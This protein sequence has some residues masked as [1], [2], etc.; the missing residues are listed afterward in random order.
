MPADNRHKTYVDPD[1]VF[2]DDLNAFQDI[3]VAMQQISHP[4]TSWAG[5]G[6]NEFRGVVASIANGAAARL[7]VHNAP[8]GTVFEW[9]QR[10]VHVR[11][12]QYVA[13]ARLPGGVDDDLGPLATYEGTLWTGNGALSPFGAGNY[14]LE[15]APG[16]TLYV[17]T[18]ASHELWID[19][20]SG[21]LLHF[22]IDLRVWPEK[23]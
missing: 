17:T 12:V 14:Y 22:V 9:W 7:D 4:T 15:I 3:V 16:V 20:Q 19:N 13:A 2:G 18:G 23:V 1:D 10:V 21:G 6:A 8:D 5:T 11:F